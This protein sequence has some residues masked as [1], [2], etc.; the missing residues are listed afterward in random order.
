MSP[1][2]LGN[3]PSPNKIGNHLKVPSVSVDSLRLKNRSFM[4]RYR[5]I[6]ATKIQILYFNTRLVI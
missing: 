5:N 4:P 3:E 6:A 1:G 2:D